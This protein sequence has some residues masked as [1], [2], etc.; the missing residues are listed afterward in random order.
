MAVEITG[1]IGDLVAEG[2]TLESF[3]ELTA[4]PGEMTKAALKVLR[5]GGIELARATID[6]P[7]RLQALPQ[8]QGL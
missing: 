5:A 4:A 2:Y 7:L 8:S 6:E 1:A 3:V